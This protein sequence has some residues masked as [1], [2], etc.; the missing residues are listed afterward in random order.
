[1]LAIILQDLKDLISDLVQSDRFTD[2]GDL[3]R[4]SHVAQP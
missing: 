3:L 2:Y 4:A 1:M